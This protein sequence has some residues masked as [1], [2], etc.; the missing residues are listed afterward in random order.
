MRSSAF[1]QRVIEA[2]TLL[3]SDYKHADFISKTGYI[4]GCDAVGIVEELG[5]DVPSEVAKGQ[6]RGFF[7]RGGKSATHGAAAEYVAV[8]YDL[9]FLVPDNT[10]DAEAASLPVCCTL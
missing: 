1:L 10:S 4:M 9:S 3:P 2:E 6:H 8:P 7:T 5:Q